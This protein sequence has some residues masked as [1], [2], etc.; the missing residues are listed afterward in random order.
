MEQVRELLFGDAVRSTEQ[1]FR[2][3]EERLAALEG[4]M[5]GLPREH[6]ASIDAIGSAIAQLGA[7]V[8][9][10]SVRKGE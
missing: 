6:A 4:K 10:L 7:T 5:V 9:S 8:Q 2:I 3:I 1:H